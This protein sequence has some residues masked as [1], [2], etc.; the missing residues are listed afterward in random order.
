VVE[1]FKTN[2]IFFGFLMCDEF[3]KPSEVALAFAGCPSDKLSCESFDSLSQHHTLTSFVIM[4][5]KV[6]TITLCGPIQ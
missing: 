4:K 3:T 1:T 2:D 5:N 6:N